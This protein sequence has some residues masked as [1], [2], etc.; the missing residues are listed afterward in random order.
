MAARSAMRPPRPY[1]RPVPNPQ[2]PEA[3]VTEAIAPSTPPA[4][5]RPL[6]VA[7]VGATG[8]VGRTM[9]A[10]LGERGFPVGELRPLA[11]RSDGRTVVFGDR[12]W[13][14]AVATPGSFEGVDVAIFSAGGETS[15]V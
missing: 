6:T 14:V 11:S 2:L 13:P 1:H 5:T 15:R 4:S 9:V 12:E 7:V 8:L 10:V 3:M